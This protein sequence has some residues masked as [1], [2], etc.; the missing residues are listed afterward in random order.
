MNDV[1]IC[2]KCRAP[3]SRVGNA[4]KCF[5]GHSFDFAKEG[6]LNLLFGNVGGTHG[7]NREMLLCRRAFLESGHYA[8]LRDAMAEYVKN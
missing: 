5:A 3:L 1:T 7:D 2:P 8:P 6:Y 4:A